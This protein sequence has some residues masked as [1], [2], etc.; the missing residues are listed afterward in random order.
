MAGLLDA[1]ALPFTDGV[2]PYL[3]DYL[4]DLSAEALESLGTLVTTLPTRCVA[5]FL[6]VAAQRPSARRPTQRV[7]YPSI[8]PVQNTSFY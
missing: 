6:T 4:A 3:D 8:P 7:T 5:R 1:Q 2:E